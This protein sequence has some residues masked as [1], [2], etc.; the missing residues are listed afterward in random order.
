MGPVRAC[1]GGA[2]CLEYDML[3]WRK[4]ALPRQPRRGDLLIYPNTAGYQMD[5]NESEFHQR[6]LPPKIVVSLDDGRLRWKL[7]ENGFHQ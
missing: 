5:K 6:P 3:T 2:S 7:D 4:V 1:V